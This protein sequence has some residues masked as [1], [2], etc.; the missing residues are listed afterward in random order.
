VYKFVEILLEVLYRNYYSLDA[1]FAHSFA[2]F[3]STNEKA[4][5]NPKSVAIISNSLERKR[6][7]FT[8]SVKALVDFYQEH[9]EDS[10]FTRSFGLIIEILGNGGDPNISSLTPLIDLAFVNHL[11]KPWRKMFELMPAT[12]KVIKEA[13]LRENFDKVLPIEDIFV[14][15]LF[16]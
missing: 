1:L 6:D 11:L 5:V 13:L 4:F 9:P 2:T 16:I 14:K 7:Y 3:F 10:F 12:Q 15:L 8:Y